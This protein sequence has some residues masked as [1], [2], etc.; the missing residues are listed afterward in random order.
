M[1]KIK[2]MQIQIERIENSIAE[3]K[4]YSQLSSTLNWIELLYYAYGDIDS[5]NILKDKVEE[6]RIEFLINT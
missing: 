3:I 4:N 5:I 1:G 2:E 6:K